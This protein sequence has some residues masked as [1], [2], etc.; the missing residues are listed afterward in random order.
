MN[1]YVRTRRITALQK[2]G[3]LLRCCK[4]SDVQTRKT[5]GVIFTCYS[6][7]SKAIINSLVECSV[8][9]E[10]EERGTEEESEQAEEKL[11]AEGRAAAGEA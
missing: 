4:S 3:F 5:R 8:G 10:A 9:E 7:L 2:K 1:N 6:K 11:D